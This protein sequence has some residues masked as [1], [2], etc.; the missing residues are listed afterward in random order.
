MSSPKDRAGRLLSHRR[1]INLVGQLN[2]R[3]PLCFPVGI[4]VATMMFGLGTATANP[5][6]RSKTIE[7]V[8]DATEPANGKLLYR[9]KHHTTLKDGEPHTSKTVYFGPKGQKWAVLSAQYA[10]ARDRFSHRYD[11]LRSGAS[12]GVELDRAG[13]PVMFNRDSKEEAFERKPYRVSSN[14]PIAVAGQGFHWLIRKRILR[15]ELKPGSSL[16]FRLLIPG[17]FDYFSFKIKTA[18]ERSGLVYLNVTLASLFLRMI[19]NAEMRLVYER[20][21]GRLVEYQ[22]PTALK[23]E[24]GREIKSVKIL[25]AYP[26]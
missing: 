22:G 21:T 19:A 26:E 10:S 20:K 15:G 17:R 5:K 6:E 8:A 24:R 16:K 13:V 11:D 12:F 9:E 3:T 4:L 14:D 18:S 25:Y 1:I 7:Y 23:D 2:L